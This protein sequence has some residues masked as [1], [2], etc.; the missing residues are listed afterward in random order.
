MI[1]KEDAQP[2][3]MAHAF[4]RVGKRS[5]APAQNPR[6]RR[7]SMLDTYYWTSLTP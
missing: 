3:I 2:L 1:Y 7:G 5:R 4:P 6:S